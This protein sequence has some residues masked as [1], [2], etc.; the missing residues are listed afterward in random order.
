MELWNGKH[1]EPW[2]YFYSMSTGAGQNLDWY[3]T[4]WFFTNNYID[5]AIENVHM[6]KGQYVVLVNNVG[7]FAIPFDVKISYEDGTTSSVHETPAIWKSNEKRQEIKIAT[8]KKISAVEL[9]GGI[10]LDNTPS[11]NIWKM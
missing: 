5:L 6:Y 4:N 9:D 3:F 2:D 1:P 7:G 11:D 10:F 8:N